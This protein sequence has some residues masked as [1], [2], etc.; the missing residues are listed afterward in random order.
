MD[1]YSIDLKEIIRLLLK[2][3]WIIA[4]STA[5]G[6]LTA[7]LISSFV[8]TPMYTARVSLY[9]SNISV[10]TS[11]SVNINDITASQKMVNTCIAIIKSESLLNEVSRLD[12]TNYTKGQL[13]E[14]TSAMAVNNT[15]LLE[16]KVTS[17]NPSDSFRIANTYLNVLPGIVE[18]IVNGGLVS[19]LDYAVMPEKPN[20]PNIP[21][22]S[23]IGGLLG[24]M[25]SVL[26]IF[27]IKVID[28]R[29]E[30]EEDLKKHYDI[31]VLGGIPE[32]SFSKYGEEYRLHEETDKK[33]IIKRKTSSPKSTIISQDTS[34][35]IKEAYA[36][37]R[38]N[39]I[40]ALAASESK[41]ICISSSMSGEGKSTTIANIAISMANNGA[42]VLLIDADFR[43]P[44][45]YKLFSLPNNK[46]LSNV[47]GGFVAL[48]EA[49]RK[50]VVTNLDVLTSGQIPPNPSELIGSK[51]MGKLLGQLDQCYDY[52]FV[53]TPPINIVTDTLA[54]SKNVNNIM[55]VVSDEKTRHEQL[56]KCIAAIEFS[57]ATISGIVINR[58]TEHSSKYKYKYKYK[59]YRE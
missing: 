16:I 11:S 30:G 2:K 12:G 47:L 1:D 33:V 41:R 42:R 45:I 24:L 7:F 15:E 5:V 6:L 57:Q 22:N 48:D 43:K 46:G 13:L 56:Q 8:L 52:I 32:F 38:T 19:P 28:A 10:N 44:G 40:F 17:P 34:F 20:S 26:F 39:L 51:S 54:L 21:L 35:G 59:A 37:V 53:D 23:A 4:L 18:K 58:S 3:W 36:K 25:L 14:M 55:L 29:V 31:P 50:D 49:V 9:V 27:L